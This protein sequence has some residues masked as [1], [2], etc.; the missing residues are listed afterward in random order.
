ML[1]L[2]EL[3]LFFKN[4]PANKNVLLHTHYDTNNRFTI[5]YTN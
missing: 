1:S 4:C 3:T 5:N 2:H